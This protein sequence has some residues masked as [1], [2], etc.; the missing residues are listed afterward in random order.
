M[1][2]TF[3]ATIILVVGLFAQATAEAGEF[4][5]V[6]G[7]LYKPDGSE[8]YVGLDACESAKI[9]GKVACVG[10]SVH[11]ANGSSVYVGEGSCRNVKVGPTFVCAGPYLFHSS[12]WNQDIGSSCG[13]V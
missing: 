4:I 1:I 11:L 3:P 9:F 10:G 13:R 5:C 12:G 6:S 7:T 8:V 2:R